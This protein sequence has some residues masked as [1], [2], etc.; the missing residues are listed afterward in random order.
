MTSIIATPAAAIST[1]LSVR[2][3]IHDLGAKHGVVCEQTAPDHLA[4]DHAG[5]FDYDVEFNHT[6]EL[7]IAL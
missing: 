6:E 1:F 5:L 4:V 2:Q 3:H 7:I